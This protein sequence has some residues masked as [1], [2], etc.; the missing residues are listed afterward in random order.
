MKLEFNCKR[1]KRN[2]FTLFIGNEDPSK[3]ALEQ[4]VKGSDL[5][6]LISNL[7]DVVYLY[8]NCIMLEDECT[9]IVTKVKFEEIEMLTNSVI[10]EEYLRPMYNCYKKNLFNLLRGLPRV[11][12]TDGF[13]NI[14]IILSDDEESEE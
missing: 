13:N 7:E 5:D 6:E 1:R 8:C 10:I 3:P 12:L 14:S 11:D 2:Q 9:G 4:L